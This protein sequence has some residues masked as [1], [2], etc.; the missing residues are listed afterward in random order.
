[1]IIKPAMMFCVCCLLQA[2][3]AFKIYGVWPMAD[4]LRPWNRRSR[5]PGAVPRWG[6]LQLH[7]RY[8]WGLWA[9]KLHRYRIFSNRGPN[10]FQFFEGEQY[11]IIHTLLRDVRVIISENSVIISEKAR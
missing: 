5:C 6:Q 7:R 4:V 11:R 10:T 1:M 9:E 8:D 2:I 3:L